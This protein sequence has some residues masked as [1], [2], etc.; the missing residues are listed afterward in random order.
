MARKRQRGNRIDGKHA[1]LEHLNTWF[2][3]RAI[4]KTRPVRDSNHAGRVLLG[5]VVDADQRRQLDCCADLLHA[6]AHGGVR[7]ML[8]V[9]DE[10]PG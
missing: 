5:H 3:P 4:D 6:L 10:A 9:V 1:D 8:V 7:G 2:E